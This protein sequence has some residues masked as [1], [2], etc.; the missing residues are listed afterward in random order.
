MMKKN[1]NRILQNMTSCGNMW[2]SRKTKLSSNKTMSEASLATSVPI[3]PIATPRS[4]ATSDGA[5]FTPSPV[6][7]IIFLAIL[8]ALT[9]L[10]LCSGETL[11]NTETFFTF[12]QLYI[13]IIYTIIIKIITNEIDK[14]TFS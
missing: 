14:R 8:K 12:S 7:A 10:S 6:I 4:A 3:L 13:F 11:A 1:K 2:N 9:I 5:S